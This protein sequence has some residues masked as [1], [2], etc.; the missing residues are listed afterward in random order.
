[1]LQ[2]GP[3]GNFLIDPPYQQEQKIFFVHCDRE[4][5][6]LRPRRSTRGTTT[7]LEDPKSH[8]NLAN[9]PYCPEAAVLGQRRD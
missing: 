5:V 7:T 2:K 1:V 8:G 4:T 6:A 3:L 9:A